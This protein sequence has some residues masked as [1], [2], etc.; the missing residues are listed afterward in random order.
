MAAPPQL[1]FQKRWNTATPRKR[2]RTDFE[3][4]ANTVDVDKCL[5]CMEKYTNAVFMECGHGG[6]CFEC[7]V[8]VEKESGMC[9]ICRAEITQVLKVFKIPG[10]V[11]EV[12][13]ENGT[14]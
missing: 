2:E 6:V 7:A 10:G 11:I 9:H 3:T 13:S 14:V 1:C 4:D 12:I 5:M 8:K